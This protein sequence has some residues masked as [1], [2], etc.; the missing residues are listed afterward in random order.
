MTESVEQTRS[1]SFFERATDLFAAPTELFDNIRDTPPTHS[2]WVIPLLIFCLAAVGMYFFLLTNDA[3]VGQIQGIMDKQFEK[4]LA[5]GRMTQAQ[6]DQAAQF[7]NPS[8]P[9]PKLI[10][11]VSVVLLSA[12]MLFVMALLYWLVGKFVMKGDAPY[13]KVVE[14]VGIVLLVG[15]LGKVVGGLMSYASSSIFA[16]ASLS[17]FVAEFDP[18]NKL[19]VFLSACNVFT[20]WSLGLVALG[21]ARL[22]RRDFPKVLVLVLALWA[23][24]ALLAL[25][26]GIRLS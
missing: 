7:M 3:I 19:H 20:F 26:T 6:A 11:S 10:Q 1:K 12:A 17:F 22:F 18:E 14:V 4:A 25:L 21:L 16:D 2:T 13:M 24:F 5:E 9:W 8:S 23:L 15:A